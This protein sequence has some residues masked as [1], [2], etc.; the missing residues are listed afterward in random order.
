ML[1]R[2]GRYT[3]ESELGKGGMGTVYRARDERLGKTVALRYSPRLEP[4]APIAASA[5]AARRELL[6]S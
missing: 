5:S 3:I 6:P 2:L 4:E 1:N